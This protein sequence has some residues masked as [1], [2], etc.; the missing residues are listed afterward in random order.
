[1]SALAARKLDDQ[2][3]SMAIQRPPLISLVAQGQAVEHDCFS[4]SNTASEP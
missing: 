3:F 4:L 1:M 2:G